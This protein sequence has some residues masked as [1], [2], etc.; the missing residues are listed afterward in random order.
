M[1]K[2]L[3]LILIRLKG[4]IQARVPDTQCLFVGVV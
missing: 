4:M 1:N 2:L 3:F